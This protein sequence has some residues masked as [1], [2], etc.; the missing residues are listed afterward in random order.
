MK[1]NK[2]VAAIEL[3]HIGKAHNVGNSFYGN[4]PGIRAT[5][6]D[7]IYNVGNKHISLEALNI[8]NE[9]SEA[10]SSHKDALPVE[11]YEGLMKAI[12]EMTERQGE[13]DFRDKYQSFMSMISDHVTIL[14]PLLPAITHLFG[15]L[16][17][18]Q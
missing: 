15:P 18:L 14:T 10:V 16:S 4:M 6:V 3:K 11:V 1:K 13:P 17:S 12:S 9:L 8:L 2:S 5:H 7:E